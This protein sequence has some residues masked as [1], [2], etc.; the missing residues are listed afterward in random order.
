MT[1]TA[2]RLEELGA[3]QDQVDAFRAIWGDGPAPMT[4]EAAVE[5]AQTFNWEWFARYLLTNAAWAEFERATAPARADR[6]RAEASAWSK[7]ER[8]EAPAWAEF[9]R[10]RASAWAEYERARA[11]AW[12]EFERA[13]ASAWAEYERACAR[14]FA[15]AYINQ[16]AA[17]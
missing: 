11:P 13:R 17:K 3:C 10:A 9:E 5:H 1:I 12:A 16:E 15:E 14:A 8:A 4:V 6:K 7:F 2:K